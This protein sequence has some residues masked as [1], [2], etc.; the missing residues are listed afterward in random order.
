[1]A[2][3]YEEVKYSRSQ[4]KKAGKVYIDPH[5]LGDEKA[6][7]LN[8]IN[9]WR[10]AHSFPLQVIYM[11]VRKV[12][13][14]GAVVAQRLKRLY[15]ITQ[16]LYRYPNMSLTTMQDI[17]GCRIIV[18]NIQQVDAMVD[19]LRKSRMRHGKKEEYDYIREPKSDGYRSY[20]MVFSYYSE[21]NPKYNGLFIEVQIRTHLQHIWATAVETM[22]TFTGD[23]LKI[24][25][26]SPE[27]RQFFVLTSR[28]LELY[29]NSGNNLSRVWE[30]D[31]RK[32]LLEYE[33][34]HKILDRLETIKVA[35]DYVSQIDQKNQG[36]YLLR[37]NRSSGQLLIR[38]YGKK[39]LEEA[40]ET[41]DL[42]ERDRMSG[43]DVVLVATSSFNMLKQAYPN[44]F[45]DISEFVSLMRT[46][47]SDRH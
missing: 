1:M 28:L 44:Y 9:N 20:H 35:V 46:F 15:S 10:A 22:D 37:L 17:G 14:S 45:V 18:D 43:E 31:A 32:E 5:A 11:H 3:N 41:Y 16:K 23:P 33:K 13:P 8:I 21:K 4:V 47:L 30:S 36:Y 19:R 26:G 40:T 25:Q 38:Q 7:A 2:H 6:T 34:M 42:A 27:N 12:A 39:Q 29:E 24:G